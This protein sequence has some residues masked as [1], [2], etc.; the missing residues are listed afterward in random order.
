M[1]S[2][3]QS[4]SAAVGLERRLQTVQHVGLVESAGQPALAA[5]AVV[6]RDEDQRVVEFADAFELVDD[7]AD[8]QVDPFHLCGEDFHLPRVEL[9][10]FV[11]S[12]SQAGISSM[13]SVS[14][15]PSGNDAQL[16]LLRENLLAGLVPAHV[17]LALVLVDV[18]VGRVV[19]R[20]HRARCPQHHERQVRL[21]RLVPGNPLDGAVGQVLVEVLRTC[22]TAPACGRST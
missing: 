22:D 1:F 21:D 18:T 7:A 19:R 20:M 9:L 16:Y 10:L 2:R 4:S 6:G 8:L 11:G 12:E 5:G 13:R 3:P 15:V 17:E 14:F